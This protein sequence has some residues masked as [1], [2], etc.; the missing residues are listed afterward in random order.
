[1]ILQRGI[2][3]FFD[4]D[5]RGVIPEFNFTDFKQIVFAVAPPFTVS[6]ITPRAVT[7]NFHSALLL[8]DDSSISM[9]GHS[10]YPLI[11]FAEPLK[12]D[13]YQ[14]Y[15]VNFDL[16]SRALTRLF[17]DVKVATAEELNQNITDAEIAQLDAVERDQIK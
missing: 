16:M 10:T 7:P 5:E 6:K 11:A 4:W 3:S 9:L 8:H 14:L 2:T 13:S 17:P 1:M 15:F 12:A